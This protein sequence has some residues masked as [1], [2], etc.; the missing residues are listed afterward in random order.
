MGNTSVNLKIP[1][2]TTQAEWEEQVRKKLSVK[3]AN[4]TILKKSLDARRKGNICWQLQLLVLSEEIKGEA[5][6]PEND[7][8]LEEALLQ[9]KNTRTAK[10]KKV[11]VAGSGPAGL[12]SAM[13]L[14][15]AGYQVKWIE[16]G[17][18][19][20]E[21]KQSID[22]FE[23]GGDF[24]TQGNYAIGEGGA[25]TFSDGKLTS[26][27]KRISRE[28]E[29][30]LQKYL[31]AGA[32]EEIAYLTH[33]HLGSDRLFHM[34][35]EMRNTLQKQGVEICFQTELE[36]LGMGKNGRVEKALIN[37]KEEEFHAYILAPG[38]SQYS[39]YRMLI[40][41]GIAFRP[42]IFALGFRAEHRQEWINRAQWGCDH[43]TGV[44]A[45]EYRLTASSDKSHRVYSFCM[46]PGGYIVPAAPTADVNL[47]NGMSLYQ[48]DNAFANA[49]VLC[50]FHPS[51]Y[52]GDDCGADAVLDW[53]EELER[54]F[55]LPGRNYA[56]PACS[57]RDFTREKLSGNLAES[58]YPLGLESSELWKMLPS[59][60]I[61]ALQ[62]G[63]QEFS[64]KL[65][66]YD[67]GMLVGLESKSSAPI[68]VVRSDNG[69]V[70]GVDNFYLA[71][72]G[73]GWAGGIIS[74]AADGLRCIQP[75]LQ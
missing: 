5:Y 57:I 4:I 10:N 31:E 30:I 6:T 72:E 2:G 14:N 46:C 60:V 34:T 3:N 35:R 75:L 65:Q 53:L 62:E 73:S 59:Q 18:P 52:L 70:E 42:K 44:K 49:A 68:Q 9:Y 66:G 37:G 50:S 58:S 74:S 28:K 8:R 40:N 22:S 20:E 26:R 51:E 69:S 7:R 71:G 29:Y 63:L 55:K 25:G 11:L 67:R 48:R 19:V 32:P 27:S 41:Q 64:R 15:E 1:V 39:T 47:V 12:F 16:K 33:P 61:E 36:D 24:P 17:L 38:H 13:A 56:A 54:S 23:A 45:A 21:R 43:L